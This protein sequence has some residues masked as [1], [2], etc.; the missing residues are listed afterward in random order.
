M[1][2]TTRCHLSE[3]HFGNAGAR[4]GQGAAWE[5]RG[6]KRPREWQAP[7]PLPQAP[8]GGRAAEGPAPGVEGGASRPRPSPARS[9]SV[10]G[11][12]DAAA[13]PSPPSHKGP[14]P[15][16]PRPSSPKSSTGRPRVPPPGAGDACSP[17]SLSPEDWDPMRPVATKTLGPSRAAAGAWPCCRD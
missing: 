10:S 1:E 16:P 12:K 3:L 17:E 8:A 11:L 9:G 13:A 15:L 7:P 4:R 6:R 2:P 14:S 5:T